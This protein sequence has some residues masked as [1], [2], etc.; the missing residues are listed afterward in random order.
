MTQ[1]P[2]DSIIFDVDGTMWDSTDLVAVSYNTIFEQE[3]L[4]VRVTADDLKKLF[5]KPMDVIFRTLLPRETPERCAALAQAAMD[6]ENEDLKVTSGVFYEGFL[7]TAKALSEKYPLF[8]VS[9][10]QCGYIEEVLRHGKLEG[11]ITDHLCFGETGTSKGRTIRTLMER[12]GLTKSVYVGDV[13]GD[14]DACVEADIPIIYC[15]Y[16]FGTIREPYAT[17]DSPAGLLEIL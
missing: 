9:N 4:P 7:E 14:A 5:G 12:H 13:Q 1:T 6:R 17:V 3:G 2:F 8:I 15:A 16:G 10:C 11:I